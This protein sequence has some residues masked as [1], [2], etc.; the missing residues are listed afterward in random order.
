MVRIR[1]VIL[2]LT[3]L[4]SRF[5]SPN[6][7]CIA[8]ESRPAAPASL[9]NEARGRHHR[10]IAALPDDEILDNQISVYRGYPGFLGFRAYP[11]APAA[12]GLW[13]HHNFLSRGVLTQDR[14]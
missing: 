9:L 7:L 12:D 11:E 14:T 13:F 1:P 4:P 2:V 3:K 6:S 5:A 10:R 8:L